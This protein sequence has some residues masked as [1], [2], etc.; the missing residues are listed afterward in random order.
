M[1]DSLIALTLEHLQLILTSVVI[2]AAIGVPGGILVHRHTGL[3]GAL[4]GLT[5]IVQTIPSLALFGFLIPIPL[6]GGI[7]KKTAILALV[8]Y[9]VANYAEYVCGPAAGGRRGSRVRDRHGNDLGTTAPSYRITAREQNYT[10]RHSGSNCYNSRYGY[11]RCCHRWGRT[12][13]L[14]LPR[15]QFE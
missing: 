9:A 12:G 15:H 4:L 7:G 8:L 14:H 6:I 2:A 1:I 11:D 3:R 13:R 10:C 5:N